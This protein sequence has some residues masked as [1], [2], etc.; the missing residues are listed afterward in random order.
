MRSALWDDGKECELTNGGNELHS[1]KDWNTASKYRNEAMADNSDLEGLE[2]I[3][4][5]NFQ[6]EAVGLLR[7]AQFAY[8]QTVIS[9][10]GA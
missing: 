1:N 6:A 4:E 9:L 7:F 5:S 8:E 10:Q 2:E 3:V